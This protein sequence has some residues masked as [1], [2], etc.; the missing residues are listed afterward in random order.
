[1]TGERAAA[2]ALV[3]FLAT[4]ALYGLAVVPSLAN[5]SDPIL[6]VPTTLSLLR[7]GDLEL[8]ELGDAIDPGHYAV[9]HLDGLPYNR[10]PIGT[11]LLILPIVWLADRL[12]PPSDTPMAHAFAIAAIAGKVLAALSVALLF[13]LL[14]ELTRA[15]WLALG[16]SLVF[17]FATVHLPIHAGGLFTH[18]AVIPLLLA[19]M[20]LVVRRDG[21]DAAW[22]AVPL[23]LAFVTRPTCVPAVVVTSA[24]IARHHPAA[25][26]RFAFLGG[27]I[28]VL[29]VGWSL[30]LYGTP[31]PPY[32]TS[33]D[34]TAPYV[35]SI[36]RFVQ[37]LVGHLVSPNRGVLVFTPILAF[38]L[39]GMARTLR[40]HGPHAAFYRM[41]ALI[42][43]VHWVMISVMA[44]KWW[45]G[46]SFG[47]RH[48]VEMLPLLVLLLV[49][50]IEAARASSRR[51]QALL[52]PPVAMALAWSLF[53]AI[54]G[55]SS[56]A[57]GA[58][59][60]TPSNVD[61][62]AERVWDWRDMQVLRR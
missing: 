58:W 29:F 57:P 34:H 47:P 19:A 24:W 51:V 28:G 48:L 30:W 12:L 50:A 25:F 22:A 16:L 40:S 23:A 33:Y 59:N 55:A 62:H 8:S 9:V 31:L 2:A 43:V 27:T 44:R 56:P 60:S 37:G 52:A 11:S 32:Y 49:P 45:A 38:S 6:I 17:G 4:G 39:W 20:L 41:V 54:H 5:A 13:V 53:V 7:D 1:M 18:N 26:P 36:G 35:M 14:V 15:P 3:L 42:V 46:W 61:D 21:R 10:Y